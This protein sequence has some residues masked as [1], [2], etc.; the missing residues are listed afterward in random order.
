MQVYGADFSGARNPSQGIYFAQGSLTEDSL[1]IERV[2]QCDDRLDLFAA[3]NSS[4]S[5]W[6]LDFPF[7][8]PASVFQQLGIKEWKQLLRE[9]VNC[10]RTGFEHKLKMSQIPNCE[11]RC[12]RVSDCCRYVDAII[13]SFSP[14]KRTNPNMRAMIYGGFKLL[15]YLRDFGN[16]VYPFDEVDHGAARLYEVYPSHT[17]AKIG[18]TRRKNLQEFA[19]EFNKNFNLKLK[20]S[21]ELFHVESLDASDAVVACT[22][23]GYVIFKYGLADWNVQYPWITQKEWDYRSQEGLIVKL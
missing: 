19:D 5:P 12:Q 9:V 15:S 4:K 2:V 23:I 16:V 3:I 18:L 17:W 13:S 6:G 20:L 1:V 11:G 8:L 7:S 21:E 22:T 10:S 14:L